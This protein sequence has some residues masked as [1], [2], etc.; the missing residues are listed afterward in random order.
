MKLATFVHFSFISAGMHNMVQDV[1][2]LQKR[3]IE[4]RLRERY[5]Q[6][7]VGAHRCSHDLINVVMGPRRA[8]KS[9]FA[10]HLVQGLGRFGYVNF[11]D[12]RLTRLQ[13]YDA[14]VAAV[15]SLYEK[16]QHLLLDEVQNLPQWELFV[17]R[18]QRQ[19]LRLTITGS[20]AHLLSSELATHLT[21][22]HVQIVLF[23]FSFSEYLSSLDHELTAHEKREALRSYAETGGYPEP[24][25]KGLAH[26]DYLTTLLR[27][28]LYKDIVVR[29]RIRS[30]QGL[31]D[32]TTCLMSNVTQEC[33]FTRLAQVTRFHSVHTVEKYLRHLEEAF[34]FFS[35]R[36][37]SFKVR[38]QVRSNRKVYCTDNGLVTSSSF[39]FSADLGKLYENLVAIALQRRRLSGE[40]DFYFW[41]GPRNEEVDFVIKR[42]LRV[43]Q[44]IQ[45][46]ADVRDPKTW[47]REVRSLLKASAELRCADLLVLTE[48][49]E[50]EEDV[51]WYGTQGRVRCVP[52]WK[53]LVASDEYL[54]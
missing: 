1:V 41:K 31:E 26:R 21:G 27:S 10:M 20:N 29:H 24:L 9:F 50:R 12:E 39:R 46:S 8:G 7:E 38:E 43:A 16:P 11:D 33:S 54:V 35:V 22:R 30:P 53:W 25:L 44:L 17:N 4:Q 14:L 5:V 45:V 3:E 28:I 2:L 47:D 34:L 32:L 49:E 48:N 19:G 36:R 23:P 6:R 52:L 42:D 40:L 37:F 13:D 18:L 15:D 51:S